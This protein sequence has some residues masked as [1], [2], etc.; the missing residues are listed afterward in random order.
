[1]A[2]RDTAENASRTLP[3]LLALGEAR[4]ITVVSSAW[5]V[6][7]P[8]FFAPYRGYGLDVGYDASFT[9]GS[10]P[11][12]V[13]EEVRQLPRARARRRAAMGAVRLPPEL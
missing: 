7:V 4:R 6:R 3:I 1:V 11:R 8:W 9:D 5:H 13:A 10:W 12:M 2:G